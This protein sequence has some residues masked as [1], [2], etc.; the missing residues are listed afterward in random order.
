MQGKPKYSEKTC[1]SAVL[2]TINPTYCS[3]ANQGRRCGKPGTNRL[4]YGTAIKFNYKYKYHKFS[5]VKLFH[6]ELKQNVWKCLWNRSTLQ[7]PCMTSYKRGFLWISVAENWIL[8]N[9]ENLAYWISI[10]SVK[11]NSIHRNV[12]LCPYVNYR[13]KWFKIVSVQSNSVCSVKCAKRFTDIQKVH[14]HHWL[15][16]VL[17]WFNMA[18]YKNFTNFKDMKISHIEFQ[19]YLWAK[20]GINGNGDLL[21][22]VGSIMDHMAKNL[23]FLSTFSE[24][25]HIKF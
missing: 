8:K 7:S 11:P 14:T 4:S 2:S 21:L 10:K 23:T 12:L 1:P 6:I 18:Q 19:K 25:L 24:S 17:L 22:Y 13:S 20:Y 16:Q 9:R 5:L 15:K 3:D